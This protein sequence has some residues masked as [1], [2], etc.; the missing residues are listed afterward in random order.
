MSATIPNLGLLSRWLN[1]E[2]YESS[3]RPIPLQQFVKVNGTV[4]DAHTKAVVRT[5]GTSPEGS[6]GKEN[7]FS[8]ASNGKAGSPQG[9]PAGEGESLLP[10]IAEVIVCFI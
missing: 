1:T 2:L 5:L 4:Y 8:K 6:A 10:L 9:P 7:E 3:F